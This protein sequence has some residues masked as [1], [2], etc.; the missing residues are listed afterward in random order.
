MD[1]GA[2]APTFSDE[3]INRFAWTYIVVI[4]KNELSKMRRDLIFRFDGFL[5]LILLPSMFFSFVM[6]LQF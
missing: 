5:V 4:N 3:H 6:K 1:E 2:Y